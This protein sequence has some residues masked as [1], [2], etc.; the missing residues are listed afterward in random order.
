MEHSDACD[1]GF[2]S[3][4]NGGLVYITDSGEVE[5]VWGGYDDCMPSRDFVRTLAN[6]LNEKA[7]C[8]DRDAIGY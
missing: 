3:S 2:N 8:F 7:V 1:A 6:L 5:S 4:I